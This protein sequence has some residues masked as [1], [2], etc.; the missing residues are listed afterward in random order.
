MLTLLFWPVYLVVGSM[1]GVFTLFLSIF[2]GIFRMMAGLFGA[3]ISMSVAFW[4]IL[5]IGACGSLIAGL[6]RNAWAL[7]GVGVLIFLCAGLYQMGKDHAD[8][9]PDDLFTRFVNG[10]RARL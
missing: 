7:V 1:G 8:G 2:R 10:M 3:A 5:L 6:L 4:P 9:H